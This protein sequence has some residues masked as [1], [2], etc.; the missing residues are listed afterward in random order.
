M[1]PPKALR[2][3]IGALLLI[4]AAL[5]LMAAWYAMLVSFTLPPSFTATALVAPAGTQSD[6]ALEAEKIRSHRILLPVVTNLN[7]QREYSTELHTPQELPP[8]A[9]SELLLIRT[10]L[11]PIRD[12]QLIAIAHTANDPS[13][14]AKIAN[15]I[16]DSYT[17]SA[18]GR[19][20]GTAAP[21]AR[22][23]EPATPASHP[24]RTNRLLPT[25]IAL[26]AAGLFAIGGLLAIVRWKSGL[27]SNEA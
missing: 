8:E 19:N 25:T 6:V 20:E 13:M 14:A 16:A 23:V 22:L 3:G 27:S 21:A 7:L 5:S 10:T 15:A 4:A 17:T 9:A 12:R 11:R 26:I 2:L 24:D 1:R 18:S